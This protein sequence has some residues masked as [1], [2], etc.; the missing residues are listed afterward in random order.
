M[1]KMPGFTA[2]ASLQEMSKP[3]RMAWIRSALVGRRR[4]MPQA[5][6]GGRA[7]M[8]LGY[9]CTPD[10]KACACS[11]VMDCINCAL[12]GRCKHCICEGTACACLPGKLP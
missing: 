2:E 11:G 8:A 10:D 7:A 1:N 4:V 5:A 12:D 9:T 6:I 3:Y